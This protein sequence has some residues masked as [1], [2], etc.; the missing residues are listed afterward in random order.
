MA[1]DI[2]TKPV[3]RAGRPHSL[4]DLS[5][6]SAYDVAPDGKRFLAIQDAEPTVKKTEL[7]FV[8]NWFEE[9]RKQVPVA[10]K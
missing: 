4:F 3:F 7:Q 5:H 1:V 8:V 2:Q 10:A 6:V 9:L